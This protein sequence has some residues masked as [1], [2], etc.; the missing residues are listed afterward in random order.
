MT[1]AQGV[2]QAATVEA[3][4]VEERG[5]LRVV[6]KLTGAAR[7]AGRVLAV[8]ARLHFYAGL[9]TVRVLTTL[10]NPDRARH[11]GGFWDLGDAGSL[12]IKDASLMLRLPA[13]DAVPEVYGSTELNAPWVKFD[14]PFEL[15]QDSSGGEH[16]QS[17]NHL[18]REHRVTTTFRGYRQ[19]SGPRA[20]SGLRA[21]PIVA[22]ARGTAGVAVAIPEFWQN[23]PQAIEA[24]EGTLT[25][26]LLPGQYSDL[27]ELQGGEQKTYEVY[28]AF[29]PDRVTS[30]PLAWCRGRTVASAVPEWCISSQ[31]IPFFSNLAADHAGLLNAAVSGPNRFE[32]KREIID[33]YGWRHFGEIYGDHEGVRSKSGTPL[34]SH[35]NNQYDAVA[36][37]AYQF[38]R[39]ADV[40]WWSAMSELARHVVDIDAVPHVAR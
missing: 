15:Y 13:S 1:D 33:E 27:H 18:N 40:R 17:H 24:A 26:R 36:G 37:F 38:L 20:Q 5:P 2:A 19:R 35:Y 39:T 9:A 21:S 7:V 6:V 25:L 4:Q 29:G 12:L 34:V 31:A 16:W 10:L 28:L 3:V 32:L 22:L 8:T 11:V 14:A 23:F 30:V